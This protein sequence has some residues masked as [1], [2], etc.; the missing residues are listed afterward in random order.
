M[1]TFV[2]SIK[3]VKPAN[4]LDVT[5]YLKCLN[6]LCTTIN[7]ILSLWEVL[8]EQQSLQFLLTRRL[9]QDPLENFLEQSDNRVEIQTVLRHCSSHEDSGN[10]STTTTLFYKQEIDQM[11]V[12]P[13]KRKAPAT[14]MSAT[15]EPQPQTS[16]PQPQTS[17]PRPFNVDV[18]DYKTYL[19]NNTVKMNAITYVAC[20]LLRKCFVKHSC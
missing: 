7:A 8:R 4:K 20:Y 10:S 11:L 6:G 18:G 15:S 2:K 17:Q 3:V 16:Q 14:N 12:E 13:L 19:E 9:N 5:C 1:L